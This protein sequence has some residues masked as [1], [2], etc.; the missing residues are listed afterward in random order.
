MTKLNISGIETD[1]PKDFP[2]FFVK[3]IPINRRVKIPKEND[4]YTLYLRFRV[5]EDLQD[6]DYTSLRKDIIIIVISRLKVC[7]GLRSYKQRPGLAEEKCHRFTADNI[8]IFVKGY[9]DGL[10][11]DVGLILS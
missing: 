9:R 4:V 2:D 6:A 1:I 3:Q 8:F 11:N 10:N 5:I 7:G